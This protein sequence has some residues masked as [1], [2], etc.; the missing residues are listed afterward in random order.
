MA[1]LH[2]MQLLPCMP[3]LGLVAAGVPVPQGMHGFIE[4]LDEQQE[5]RP[6]AKQRARWLDLGL[7]QLH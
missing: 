2:L 6:P 1:S 4:E 7:H 5:Q 3:S